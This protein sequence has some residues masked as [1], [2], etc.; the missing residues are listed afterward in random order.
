M[1]SRKPLE[2]RPR[3]AVFLDRDGVINKT[4]VR[5]GISHPPAHLDDFEFLPGVIEAA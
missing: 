1:R 4:F 5:S 2:E 3:P